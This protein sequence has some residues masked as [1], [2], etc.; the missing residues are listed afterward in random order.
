MGERQSSIQQLI[1][2]LQTHRVNTLTGLCQIERAAA[3]CEDEA[4]AQAF[5]GP[6]TAAWDYYVTSRQFLSELR[7]LSPSYPFAADLVT[8][9]ERRVRADPNSNR[10]WNLPWM[11]LQKMVDE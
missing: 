8:E 7:G 9:A 1:E 3:A 5:Q 6:M 4:D 10:S 11:C 2:S